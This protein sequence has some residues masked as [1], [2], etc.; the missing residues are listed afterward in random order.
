MRFAA[1]PNEWAPF[2]APVSAVA[3][4]RNAVTLN[5]V[6]GKPGS[7]ATVWFD[8]PGF[9]DEVSTPQAFPMARPDGVDGS[10]KQTTNGERRT[11]N[12]E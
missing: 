2:R 12:G 6:P 10:K 4:E 11:D 3:L 8:P 7:P 1:Q 5:V 9:V